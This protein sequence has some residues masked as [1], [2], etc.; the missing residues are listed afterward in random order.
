[1][2]SVVTATHDPKWLPETADSL[3]AQTWKGE[4]EWLIYLNNGAKIEF[5]PEVFSGL[6]IRIVEDA[7][8]RKNIG[9]VKHQAFMAAKGDI[10]VE[11][12]HDDLLAPHA[13]Q[14]VADAFADPSLEFAYSNYAEFWQEGNIAG[15]DGQVVHHNQWDPNVYDSSSGWLHR[16]REFYGHRF[17]EHRTFPPGPWS[18]RHVMFAPNHLRAWRADA[19][20]AIGGH[21][22]TLEVADD[23]DLCC[24][25]YLHGPMKWIDDCLYLYRNHANNSWRELVGKA[26][27]ISGEL[28][29]HRYRYSLVERWC[30][31]EGLPK[32][33]LGGGINP[34]GHG[35]TVVDARD[36]RGVDHVCRVGKEPLP[37]ADNSIGLLRAHDFLE[38]IEPQY[39]VAAMND[40]YRVLAPGGWLMTMTPSTDGRGAFQDPTHRSFLNSNSFWY[41]TDQA[42]A[43]FVPEIKCRFQL[44]T[45]RND[46]PSA[47]QK[48]HD[49]VYV[50]A[51]MVALKQG[52]R[53]PGVVKI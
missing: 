20:R 50:Y 39:L 43:Q 22:V 40:F 34:I 44:V 6:P 7:T 24:K 33:D 26:W 21:D 46:Y 35:W 15:H 49:I 18:F 3:R 10:H 52:L 5:S 1:M 41:Y 27:Q 30:E 51:D 16:E 12:D 38:H 17:V 47:W 13:L 19:Y 28:H 4:W 45:I 32:V 53:V 11:L 31:L 14:A 25:F 8:L 23:H 48:E 9:D 2:I 29:F 36:M 37:F 42:L